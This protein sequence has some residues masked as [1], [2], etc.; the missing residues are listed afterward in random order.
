MRDDRGM[1]YYIVSSDP[2]TVS[3]W[4]WET[5]ARCGANSVPG[6]NQIQLR[7][8]PAWAVGSDKADWPPDASRLFN[9]YFQLPED[10]VAAGR[11]LVDALSKYLDREEKARE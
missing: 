4:L 10:P 8:D 2:Q 1:S 11:V 3:R 5:L 7:V 9:E 6:Y